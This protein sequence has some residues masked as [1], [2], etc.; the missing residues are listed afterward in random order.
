MN[1]SKPKKKKTK[2]KQKKIGKIYLFNYWI[3]L[4][5]NQALEIG[6]CLS[7]DIWFIPAK[8]EI[9]SFVLCNWF[10]QIRVIFFTSS[11]LIF[12]SSSSSSV[13]IHFF[14]WIFGFH[15]D[16]DQIVW[17]WMLFIFVTRIEFIFFDFQSHVSI[18]NFATIL[19]KMQNKK[20]TMKYFFDA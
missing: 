14:L 12:V 6:A 3:E 18:D 7:V 10:V 4:I 2:K 17:M 8:C 9:I 1:N 15:F 13:L 20:K 11:V 16:A 19:W 5:I